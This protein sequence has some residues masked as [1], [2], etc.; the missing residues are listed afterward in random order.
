MNTSIYWLHKVFL[1]LREYQNNVVL[2]GNVYI[3]K[4]FYKVI[5]SD[6]ET[7]EGKQLRGLSHNQ[8]CIGV[9]YDKKHIMA[10]V[11]GLWKPSKDKT[12]TTFMV[13]IKPNSRLIHDDEKSHRIM[14]KKL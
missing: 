7:K 2:S 13:H 14:V 9:G 5:K 3:D 12:E 11:E 1:I 4:M 6:I 8:Y 10:I